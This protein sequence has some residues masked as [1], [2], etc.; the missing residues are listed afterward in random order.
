VPQN[1]ATSNDLHSVQFMDSNTGYAA[2]AY[3]TV[4]KTTN[5]GANWIA[6]NTGSSIPFNALHFVNAST[7]SV[8]GWLWIL[9][10]T[11]GD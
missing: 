6:L 9:M 11:N 3:G 8:A 4:L 5:G 7:G 10:T 1:S 2:G